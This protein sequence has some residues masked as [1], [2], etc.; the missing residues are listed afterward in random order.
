VTNALL[1]TSTTQL[2][3]R[4]L[5]ALPLS[6]FHSRL[7]PDLLTTIKHQF[8]T[9]PSPED[10]DPD[11]SKFSIHDITDLLGF[12]EAFLLGNWSSTKSSDSDHLETAGNKWLIEG[13]FDLVIL[14][15]HTNGSSITRAGRPG[16]R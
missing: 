13:L 4:T 9:V 1:Q 14:L 5:K 8:Q 15:R 16:A 12:L 10:E 3:I 7:L 2:I 6:S 11:L